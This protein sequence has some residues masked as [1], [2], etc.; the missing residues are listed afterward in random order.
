MSFTFSKIN[1]KFLRMLIAFRNYSSR[2]AFI[3]ICFEHFISLIFRR[4]LLIAPEPTN[5]NNALD[6][7]TC[8]AY[9]FGFLD[10]ISFLLKNSQST[11][12]LGQSLF[13]CSIYNSCFDHIQRDSYW[14]SLLQ[15]G[16]KKFHPQFSG[17]TP[18][19]T[20]MLAFLEIHTR[21]RS[22]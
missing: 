12:F 16:L 7:G 19:D 22:N 10:E 11:I 20:T 8:R 14:F 2:L 13:I 6:F 15:W 17:I 1:C 5:L 9:S 18:N 4:Q 3:N 21:C